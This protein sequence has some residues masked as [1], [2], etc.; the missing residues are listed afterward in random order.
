VEFEGRELPYRGKLYRMSVV[1][2]IRDRK[3]AEARIH[4]LAHHDT[5]TGLPNRAL[6]LDR[7]QFILAAAKRRD[8]H[9]AVLFIDLD[10]FKIVNDSLGHAAGDSLL[11]VVAE[12]I[13]GRSGAATRLRA[14]AATNSSSCCPIS[15]TSRARYPWRRSCSY[16]SSGR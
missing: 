6:M 16:R 11:K 1:R 14:S 8:K 3:A 15:T 9:V 4:F 13:Q 10:N 2:D 7:L 12:R 5:L